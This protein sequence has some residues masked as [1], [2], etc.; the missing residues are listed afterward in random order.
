[1]G[2][3]SFFDRCVGMVG[4]VLVYGLLEDFAFSPCYSLGLV[5][6]W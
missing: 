1:M 6:V 2:Q 4:D 3:L 5:F